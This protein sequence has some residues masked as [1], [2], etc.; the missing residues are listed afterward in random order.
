M[1]NNAKLAM[2]N[3]LISTRLANFRRPFPHHIFDHQIL[4]YINLIELLV[5]RVIGSIED[6][7]CFFTL[8]FMITKLRNWLTLLLELV[9]WTFNQKFFTMQNF[10]FG[11]TIQSWKDNKI[12]YGEWWRSYLILQLPFV[13]MIHV[14]LEMVIHEY[15]CSPLL[16][17]LK[18]RSEN[19][20]SYIEYA[21]LNIFFVHV[22]LYVAMG[23]AYLG[24]G[25][26]LP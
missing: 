26:I 18:I 2:Q 11:T 6:E 3:H 7:W 1:K 9:I 25:S 14:C 5:M 20:F 10:S 23:R 19:L 15:S 17:L 4:E 16:G 13:S 21:W 12:H 8:T 22:R 24:Q